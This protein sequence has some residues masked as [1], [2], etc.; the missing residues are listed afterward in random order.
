MPLRGDHN[1]SLV[2]NKD[3]NFRQ[4]KTTQFCA[5]IQQFARSADE[6]MIIYLR[7]SWN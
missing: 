7:T 3:L 6:Y 5:P 2:E 1:V 4:I